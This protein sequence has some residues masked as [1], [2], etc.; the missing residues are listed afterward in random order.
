M[1]NA[2]APIPSDADTASA[3]PT[4]ATESSLE[5]VL[6]ILAAEGQVS[7]RMRR[8][9]ELALGVVP[10]SEEIVDAYRCGILTAGAGQDGVAVLTPQRLSVFERRGFRS[11]DQKLHLLVTRPFSIE[12]GPGATRL[13]L[14]AA[15]GRPT[16]LD[17]FEANRAEALRD[18]L[19]ALRSARE[20]GW[21][22]D[23]SVPWPGWLGAGPTWSYLGGDPR[24]PQPALDLRLQV[25]PLGF[26]LG[27]SDGSTAHLAPWSAVS[28]LHVIDPTQGF[29]RAAGRGFLVSGGFAAA[30]RSAEWSAFLVV[31]YVTGEQVFLGT[32]GL[33]EAEL[34]NRLYPVA[35]AMPADGGRPEAPV[36]AEAVEDEPVAE[37]EEPVVAEAEEPPVAGA[38]QPVAAE[39]PVVVFDQAS[40]PDLAPAP[41]SPAPAYSLVEQLERLGALYRDGVL[42]GDEFVRAKAA[43]LRS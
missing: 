18:E 28:Y 8:S 11:P 40:D 3:F 25:G 9:A 32:T 2:P 31:G 21:W 24:F 42:D 19:A 16:T 12:A 33:T 41:E 37:A 39:Q 38:E 17:L 5:S 29:E 36:G 7:Q 6:R 34:R 30:W 20:D 1:S 26:T 23:T 27:D 35:A 43:L 22:A 13:T 10:P 14:A 4:R 15:G